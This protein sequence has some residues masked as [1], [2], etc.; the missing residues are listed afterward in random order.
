M[1]FILNPLAAGITL[2]LIMLMNNGAQAAPL[3]TQQAGHTLVVASAEAMQQDNIR[4]ELSS[5]T[6]CRLFTAYK[7]QSPV[8]NNR[9]QGS[10][11]LN[12]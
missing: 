9:G 5:E 1:R 6:D 2:L 10:R 3:I 8:I 7:S 11:P 12:Y 4:A